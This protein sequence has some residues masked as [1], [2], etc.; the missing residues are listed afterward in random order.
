MKC[1]QRNGSLHTRRKESHASCQSLLTW[2]WTSTCPPCPGGWD[3][4]VQLQP[5][6][7]R[8]AAYSLQQR[9]CKQQHEQMTHREWLLQC[10]SNSAHILSSIGVP[11]RCMLSPWSLHG[12]FL[13]RLKI[14][15]SPVVGVT[16]QHAQGL[17]LH[18]WGLWL[19]TNRW[20]M[21]LFCLITTHFTSLPALEVH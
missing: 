6:P 19:V 15:H 9:Q 16:A 17:G 8:S 14:S 1:I 12:L 21:S 11:C 10:G 18:S 7:C 4:Q 13:R 20:C 5:S 2:T 3:S